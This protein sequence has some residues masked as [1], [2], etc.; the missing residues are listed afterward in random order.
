[1]D[2]IVGAIIAVNFVVQ[3][4]RRY[5]KGHIDVL[6]FQG[7]LRREFN[8]H[9][10][11]AE[12]RSDLRSVTHAIGRLMYYGAAKESMPLRITGLFSQ[13]ITSRSSE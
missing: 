9:T 8:P 4:E 3:W 11:E 7:C 12:L 1:M 10:V 5:P 13:K 2:E 6:A